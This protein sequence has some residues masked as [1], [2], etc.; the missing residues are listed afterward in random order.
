MKLVV[1]R[2]S[3]ASVEVEGAI[4][5]EIQEGL[6]VLVGFGEN[7]TQKEADYLSRKL[8]KL[9]IF[10]D[11][12]GSLYAAIT[13]FTNY[14]STFFASLCYFR[15]STI[16]ITGIVPFVQLPEAQKA[17]GFFVKNTPLHP[18]LFAVSPL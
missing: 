6:M 15:K 3:N 2:V 16:I 7:D 1:Q 5:G 12:N 4:V 9:R 14:Y 10:P 13:M 18:Q 8:V 11:E 17:G